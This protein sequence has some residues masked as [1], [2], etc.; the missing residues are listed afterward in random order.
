MAAKEPPA[1]EGYY[2]YAVGY[3]GLVYLGN[4]NIFA[5]IGGNTSPH[6]LHGH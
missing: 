3:P 5:Q 6:K 1:I 4:S 2:D